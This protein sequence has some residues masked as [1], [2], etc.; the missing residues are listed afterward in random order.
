MAYAR[1]HQTGGNEG[2]L[3]KC[4]IVSCSPWLLTRHPLGGFFVIIQRVMS[5]NRTYG[6]AKDS[7]IDGRFYY[8]ARKDRITEVYY[9]GGQVLEVFSQDKTYVQLEDGSVLRLP[10]RIRNYT[11]ELG[12]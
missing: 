9:P 12:C 2:V 11:P 6:W 5:A 3:L 4:F 10:Q 7:L 8:H 1:G